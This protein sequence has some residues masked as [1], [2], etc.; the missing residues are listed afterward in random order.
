[1]TSIAQDTA[2]ADV[3]NSANGQLDD[4]AFCLGQV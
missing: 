3:F 1:V 2:L 4:R